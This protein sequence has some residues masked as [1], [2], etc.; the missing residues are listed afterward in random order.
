MNTYNKILI[1]IF[2]TLSG[3]PLSYFFQ[4]KWLQM[5]LSFFEYLLVLIPEQLN[6]ENKFEKLSQN[7]IMMNLFLTCI[8]TF[9]A[10]VIIMLILENKKKV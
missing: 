3:I 7:S 6:N 9:V 5:S 8:M 2:G 4:N 1:L 10:S